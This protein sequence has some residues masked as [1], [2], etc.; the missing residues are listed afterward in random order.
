MVWHCVWQTFLM[1]NSGQFWRSCAME[2]EG[3]QAFPNTNCESTNAMVVG[4]EFD[5]ADGVAE[6]DGNGCTLVQEALFY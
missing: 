5:T 2:R 1:S 3:N 6:K 4:S